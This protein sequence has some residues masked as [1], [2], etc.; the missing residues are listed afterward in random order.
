MFKKKRWQH[1]KMTGLKT[2]NSKIYVYNAYF[3]PKCNY[4]AIVQ[5][6]YCPNCG[7]RLGKAV[8]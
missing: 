4:E 8:K 7:K 1:V 3:C 2:R 6:N 5:T